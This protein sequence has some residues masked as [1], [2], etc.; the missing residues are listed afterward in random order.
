MTL[1]WYPIYYIVDFNMYHHETIDRV[2]VWVK[3]VLCL[4]FVIFIML[5][6]HYS[7]MFMYYMS[8]ISCSCNKIVKLKKKKKKKILLSC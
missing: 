3:A 1:S 7:N 4:F 6:I 5:Y 8:C 2:N